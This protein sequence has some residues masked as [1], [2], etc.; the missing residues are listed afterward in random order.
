[1]HII[2]NIRF[3][4][5]LPKGRDAKLRVYGPAGTMTAWP[6]NGLTNNTADPSLRMESAFL[7]WLLPNIQ[8]K[9]PMRE[10]A[11]P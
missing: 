6:P 10:V 5:N 11:T 3:M 1:M 2:R 4:A 8:N 9:H 7:L